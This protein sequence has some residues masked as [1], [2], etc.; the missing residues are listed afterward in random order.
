MNRPEQSWKLVAVACVAM[1][2]ATWVVTLIHANHAR[3]RYEK[4]SN[5]DIWLLWTVD[6]K[7]GEVEKL[8]PPGITAGR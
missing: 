8:S 3:Y 7:T 5:S 4:F 1:V 6:T 2:C